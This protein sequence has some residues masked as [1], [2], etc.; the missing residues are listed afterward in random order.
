MEN[1][2]KIEISF[3]NVLFNLTK[4][5]LKK[6]ENFINEFDNYFDNKKD[7]YWDF[8][9][10]A[11]IKLGMIQE[12]E[13][14][15]ANLFPRTKP[16]K[17]IEF[18]NELISKYS[19]LL[20][21]LFSTNTFLIFY[22]HISKIENRNVFIN[23]INYII[24]NYDKKN[25]LKK[26]IKKFQ[27]LGIYD[28][29]YNDKFDFNDIYNISSS[30]FENIGVYSDGNKKWLSRVDTKFPVFISDANYIIEY[31]KN[32]N[33]ICMKLK[34]LE[35][36]LDTLPSKSDLHDKIVCNQ[37]IDY[38]ESNTKTLS[39][40]LLYQLNNCNNMLDDLIPI[41][42]ALIKILKKTKSKDLSKKFANKLSILSSIEDDLEELILFLIKQYEKQEIM[43]KDELD[44]SINRKNEYI[45]TKGNNN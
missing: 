28:F 18:D 38:N 15:N 24:K 29:Y 9:N 41:S 27:E 4:E 43:S 31:N 5:D 26:Y 32:N 37:E 12:K 23:F 39:V 3:V 25:E 10:W 22:C 16:V 1:A 7:N 34:N 35:F 42:E 45:K 6:I 17:S 14:P 36:D 21:E 11:K 40:D 30:H 33:L 19:S 2:V 20:Y 13:Q 44:D 8:E